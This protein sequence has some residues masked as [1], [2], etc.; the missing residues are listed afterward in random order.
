MTLA[1]TPGGVGGRAVSGPGTRASE[2]IPSSKRDPPRTRALSLARRTFSEAHGSLPQARKDWFA[3]LRPLRAQ[4]HHL[5]PARHPMRKKCQAHPLCDALAAWVPCSRPTPPSCAR[6]EG[7]V[8]LCLRASPP[9]P[10]T[11]SDAI[12]CITLSACSALPQQE[13]HPFGNQARVAER[14]FGCLHNG[15]SAGVPTSQASSRRTRSS[16]LCPH[17]SKNSW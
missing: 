9:T 3:I 7:A 16:R 10:S 4:S 12:P 11:S 13:Q 14:C 15:R 1:P 5:R 8:H 6:S 2:L 17:N